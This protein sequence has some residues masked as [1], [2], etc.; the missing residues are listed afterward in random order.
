MSAS[1]F[2]SRLDQRYGWSNQSSFVELLIIVLEIGL[3]I[4]GIALIVRL[5]T[6]QSP[7]PKR[8]PP[9]E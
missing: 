9:K 1:L 6:L 4:L 2:L 8:P 5:I 3:S 7:N